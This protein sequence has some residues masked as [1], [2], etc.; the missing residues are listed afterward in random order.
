MT[1]VLGYFIFL[2]HR[3][4]F[5]SEKLRGRSWLVSRAM[6]LYSIRPFFVQSMAFCF[7]LFGTVASRATI[8]QLLDH[9]FQ[10]NFG[11]DYLVSND[12]I[13]YLPVDP[14]VSQS[15]KNDV[16]LKPHLQRVPRQGF[17]QATAA[18]LRSEDDGH[19]E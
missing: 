19:S 10:D 6:I 14:N 15:E 5:L 18:A 2:S 1:G 7:L 12:M 11:T 17:T 9:G 13:H 4:V 8:A 16:V 3:F